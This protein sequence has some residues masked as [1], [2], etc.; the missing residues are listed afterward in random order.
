[1]ARESMQFDVVVVGGGPAGLASAIRL[2][3]LAAQAVELGVRD[4]KRL[5]IGAHILLRRRDG[6][7]RARGALPGL[8][9]P[10]RPAPD[11]GE[12]DGSFFS[13]VRLASGAGISPARM[14][15]E[16]RQLRRQPRQPVPLAGQQA[17]ALGVEIYPALP[18][19]K[20]FT[21]TGA[22]A[23]SRYRRH[24]R[25]T[26]R[27]ADRQVP[28]WI[29]LRGK[30]V[31]FAEGCRG[32]LGRQLMERYRLGADSD[33][34]D[35][36]NRFKEL[37]KSNRGSISPDSFIHSAGWPL[38]ADAYGGS[39][40][41]HMQDNL[42]R[43]FVRGTRLRQPYLDPYEEFQR[44]KPIRHPRVPRSGKRVAYGA[45]RSPRAA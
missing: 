33:P 3:Q 37:W 42:C 9:T 12:R 1:M 7:A 11:P 23:R 6:P 41:Y 16:P 18:P 21:T 45:A 5:E 36:R 2:K 34:Q 27:Q 44:Y 28:A 35:L 38:S 30:Y 19:R 25:G 26:R 39:F 40:L 22:R 20:C 29:E 4:R 24:G 8:E 31:F 14:L 10:R 32:H 15:R 13:P 17:E 43:W